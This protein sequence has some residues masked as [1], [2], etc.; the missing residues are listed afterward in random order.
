MKLAIQD[1]M[2]RPIV[3]TGR[4]LLAAIIMTPYVLQKHSDELRTLSRRDIFFAVFAGVL[5]IAHFLS[6]VYALDSTSIMMLSVILNTGPLWTALLERTFLKE[7]L[8]RIIWIGLLITIAGGV[9]IAILNSI[10]TGETSNTSLIGLGLV[11]FGSISGSAI[12]TIGRSV[13]AKVSMP[14]YSWIVFGSGGIVGL[15]FVL[16][17]HT[18]IF[19][20]PSSGYFWLIVLTL[21]PQIVGHSGFNYV[22]KFFS[23]TFLSITGQSITITASVAAYF[24]LHEIPGMAEIFGST[25]ILSGVILAIYGRGQLKKQSATQIKS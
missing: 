17:T 4:L 14:A 12:L 16:A 24:M 23:A 11:L 25:I 22:V 8:N 20:H 3:A 9:T 10:E 1:G 21:L 7:H 13:R 6:I 18:P 19:G 15:I 2:P 5:F